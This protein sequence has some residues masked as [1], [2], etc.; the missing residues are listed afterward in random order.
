MFS[1][2]DTKQ[3][4]EGKSLDQ[5][6]VTDYVATNRMRFGRYK[7][8]E[9]PTG[10]V[11]YVVSTETPKI[12]RSYTWCGSIATTYQTPPRT[13]DT[14]LFGDSLMSTDSLCVSTQ[15]QI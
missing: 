3:K 12:K 2:K 9:P 6:F 13:S 11:L 15:T 10:P 14:K 5:Q 4:K 1:P 7:I 8:Q